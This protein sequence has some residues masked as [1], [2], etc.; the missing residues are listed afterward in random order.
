M[1]MI[2]KKNLQS[3]VRRPGRAAATAFVLA[4]AAMLAAAPAS[5]RDRPGTPN[6]EALGSCSLDP[7]QK[8]SLCL[9]FY[10][11]AHEDVR[12]EMEP[13]RTTVFPST[14]RKSCTARPG[15]DVT[16]HRHR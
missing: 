2:L 7:T 11:T 13:C 12:I 1:I 3:R 6:G 15:Q 5:A 14:L 4:G 8:P 9:S 10:N 16:S